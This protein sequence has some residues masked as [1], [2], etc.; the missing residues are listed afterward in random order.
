MR[1]CSLIVAALVLSSC[2]ERG[3]PPERRE[4]VNA[5]GWAHA[6]FPDEPVGVTC[7]PLSEWSARAVCEVSVPGMVFETI[8]CSP[9]YKD[10]CFRIIR[11]VP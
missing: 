10:A 8:E 4:V 9:Y 2:A 11:H 1:G 7:G 3:S 6:H 5:R